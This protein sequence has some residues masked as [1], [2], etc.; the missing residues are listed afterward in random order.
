VRGRGLA[1]AGELFF[2]RAGVGWRRPAII[3][4]P[5]GRGLAAAGEL[6]FNRGVMAIALEAAAAIPVEGRGT[7]QHRRPCSRWN[8][9]SAA[10]APTTGRQG[11]S[12]RR[13]PLGLSGEARACLRA[14]RA[15]ARSA[16]DAAESFATER[17]ALR[18][19]QAIRAGD[20]R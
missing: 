1:A 15:G 19:R 17:E 5:R 8:E 6:L 16:Q 14:N 3:L 4:R 20:V 18:A 12:R 7:P 13:H 11:F 2:D 10:S 9:P